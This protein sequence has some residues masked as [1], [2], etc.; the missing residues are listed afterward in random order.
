LIAVLGLN[1]LTGF[2]GQISIGHQAF[3]AVGA[4]TTAVLMDSFNWSFWATLPLAGIMAAAVGVLFGLPS[5][6]LKML[7]LA[8]STLAAQF[9][10]IAFFNHAFPDYFHAVSGIRVNRP[11][12]WG[13]DFRQN[14]PFYYVVIVLTVLMTFFAKNLVRSRLGRAFV[15]IR[16]NDL[17]SGVIGINVA[18]YKLYAFAIG[19]FYAGI[20]G[21]LWATY[22]RNVNPMHFHLDVSIW[23]LGCLIVGGMGST[24]GSVF[25]V[26]FLRSIKE[27]VVIVSPILGEMVSPMNAP[28]IGPAF[29]VISWALVVILFLIFEPRGLAHTWEVLKARF[30]H[31]PFKYSF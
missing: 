15:A 17:A 12:L 18:R 30:R 26:V 8:M 13:I 16:D 6:R 7:Y 28:K 19:C 25:G 4:Y 24:V 29:G 3:V 31:W 10:I 1:I 11:E 22:Y 20:S 14:G 23:Y 5:F 2:A 21:A 27:L 9:I